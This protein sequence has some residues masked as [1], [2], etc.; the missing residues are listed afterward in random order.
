V[1][2]DLVSGDQPLQRH[3]NRL[4]EKMGAK[5]GAI[6]G[7]H[8]ATTST[9]KCPVS[10]KGA[11]SQRILPD[12]AF[13][14]ITVCPVGDYRVSGW[15]RSL[16][17]APEPVTSYADQLVPSRPPGRPRAVDVHACD[18]AGGFRITPAPPSP[19]KPGA[20]W[21]GQGLG[22]GGQVRRCEHYGDVASPGFDQR[23]RYEVAGVERRRSASW[24]ALRAETT[25]PLRSK[26]PAAFSLS[27]AASAGAPASS[28]TSA[29][30]SRP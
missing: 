15:G 29:K 12:G 22:F 26:S 21:Y 28:R 23:S 8:R 14:L 7:R 3:T 6:I 5:W 13:G 1:V 27:A 19:A 24:R 16:P 25:F 18:Y 10:A 11:R 20:T 30:S 17:R 4:D 9:L 2:L